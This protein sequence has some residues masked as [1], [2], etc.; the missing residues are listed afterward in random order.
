[1]THSQ[2]RQSA[3]TEFFYPAPPGTAGV[4]IGIGEEKETTKGKPN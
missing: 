4:G 1:M 2:D 3:A